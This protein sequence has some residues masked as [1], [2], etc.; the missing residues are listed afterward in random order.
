ML[1][2]CSENK[3]R[4]EEYL[5]SL[6]YFLQSLKKMINWEK[7]NIKSITKEMNGI[8]VMKEKQ[9]MM[10]QEKQKNQEILEKEAEKYLEE[11]RRI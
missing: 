2:L 5:A 4:N 8:K 9:F 10:E 3:T 1:K 7:E 11:K 6:N